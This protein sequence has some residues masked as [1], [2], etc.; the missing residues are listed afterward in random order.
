MNKICCTVCG[1]HAMLYD[2]PRFP[3]IKPCWNCIT[4]FQLGVVRLIGVDALME[5]AQDSFIFA[6]VSQPHWL[7]ESNT[8]TFLPKL[9]G[10][11]N[12]NP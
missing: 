1:K 9:A 12:A 3:T 7:I 10:K 4:G 2:I 6:F 8:A 11:Y 5:K